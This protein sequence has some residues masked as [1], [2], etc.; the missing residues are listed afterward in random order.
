MARLNIC[1]QLNLT[2]QDAVFEG[3]YVDNELFTT[4]MEYY[5]KAPNKDV[6]YYA[7]FVKKQ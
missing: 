6:T 5:F 3:W 1:I 4:N 2:F 7:R